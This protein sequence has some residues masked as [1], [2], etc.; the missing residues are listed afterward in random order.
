MKILKVPSMPFAEVSMRP[1]TMYCHPRLSVELPESPK[2]IYYGI[3][4]ERTEEAAISAGT[5]PSDHNMQNR[6][7]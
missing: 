2:I 3:G 1:N 4:Q 7:I 5:R 6:G